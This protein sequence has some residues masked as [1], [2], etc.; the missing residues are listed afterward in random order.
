[1]TK[2]DTDQTLKIAESA[3][4]HD[5]LLTGHLLSAAQSCVETPF[6][7][8]LLEMSFNASAL[9]LEMEAALAAANA[10]EALVFRPLLR[11]S[12][13]PLRALH[14]PGSK[15]RCMSLLGSSVSS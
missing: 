4:R 13:E 1:M 11:P 8:C 6:S 14:P 7:L 5:H 2:P 3:E 9:Y 15:L 10:N 12:R